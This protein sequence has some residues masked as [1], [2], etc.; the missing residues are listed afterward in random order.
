MRPVVQGA[1]KG[2][3][4]ENFAAHRAAN[5]AG[6]AEVGESLAESVPEG[7]PR[8]GLEDG[9]AVGESFTYRAL[10]ALE[11]GILRAESPVG[12]LALR[13]VEPDVGD[14]VPFDLESVLC[15][16]A[17]VVAEGN[18]ADPFRCGERAFVTAL[19]QIDPAEHREEIGLFSGFDAVEAVFTVPNT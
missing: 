12:S 15:A 16:E 5:G 4:V 13:G 14:V 17:D 19:H 9:R 11:C 3:L 6:T 8:R 2:H 7:M 1:V 10:D 18:V